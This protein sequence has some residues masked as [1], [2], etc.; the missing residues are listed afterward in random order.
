MLNEAF[1]RAAA[2]LRKTD[3]KGAPIP[4][5]AWDQEQFD[6]DV[7]KPC[8]H[9]DG[10]FSADPFA[11]CMAWSAS[12]RLN[13]LADRYK[14]HLNPHADE[15]LPDVQNQLRNL[16]LVTK[17]VFPNAGDLGGPIDPK[18]ETVQVDADYDGD[19]KTDSA[20]WRP[21]DGTWSVRPS[22]GGPVRTVRLGQPGDLPVPADYDGTGKAEPAVVRPAANKFYARQLAGDT[23]P[24]SQEWLRP[25]YQPVPAD[26][27]KMQLLAGRLTQLAYQFS[28]GGKGSDAPTPQTVARDILRKLSQADARYRSQLGTASVILGSFLDSA[29]KKTEALAPT[30]EGVDIFRALG[31]KPNLAWALTNLAYR[32]SSAGRAADAP[33]AEREARDIYRALGDKLNLANSSVLLG[34]FDAGAKLYDE[35]VTVTKEGVDLYRQL[36]DKANLAWAL[37]NLAYRLSAAGKAAD[38]PAPEQEAHD[39]YR[40]LG[41]KANQANSAVILGS[42][43]SGAGRHDEAIAAAKEGVDGYRQLG[44]QNHLGWALYNLAYRYAAANRPADAATAERESRDI[45]RTLA[46]ADLPTYQPQWAEAAFL[47]GTWLKQSNQ[48]PEARTAAQEAVDQ[49]TILAAAN[50]AYNARLTDSRNLRASLG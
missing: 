12:L 37:T 29:G 36:G 6:G 15:S 39:I 16:W 24:A 30:Q 47:L 46:K 14:A 22:T 11:N 18:Q 33:P 31:D 4:L 21:S 10:I 20:F 7:S 38:A 17:W 26:Y 44:D 8:G 35:S 9:V 13:N 3:D 5:L 1:A 41:D 42:F 49:F 25:D 48:I 28:S 23:P 45:Y 27:D 43:L 40:S 32:F 19:H 34:S 50:P 2:N